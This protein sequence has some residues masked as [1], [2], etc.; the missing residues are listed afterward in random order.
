M[1]GRVAST[2]VR[3]AIK[4]Y[5]PPDAADLDGDG[6]VESSAWLSLAAEET[7]ALGI[8]VPEVDGV[9]YDPIDIGKD[10]FYYSFDYAKPYNLHVNTA[11]D[12][13]DD[14]AYVVQQGGMINQP[15][16]CSPW[17]ASPPTDTNPDVTCPER[18]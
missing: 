13:V 2:R 17:F 11:L 8:T 12:A 5:T 3:M 10:V 6:V 16:Q 14:S 4:P 9:E 7:K 18:R 15:A 1:I